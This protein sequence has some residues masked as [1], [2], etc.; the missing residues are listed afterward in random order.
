M[1][2]R[3]NI[4]FKVQET[5]VRSWFEE[6]LRAGEAQRKSTGI[7][8]LDRSTPLNKSSDSARRSKEQIEKLHHVHTEEP[9]VAKMERVHEQH[10]S[11]EATRYLKAQA[12]PS[13]WNYFTVRYRDDSVIPQQDANAE[14]PT[15]PTNAPSP[16][17]G[18]K[19][20][21][22]P[23]WD[24]RMAVNPQGARNLEARS[25]AQLYAHQ[26]THCAIDLVA[27]DAYG[28]ASDGDRFYLLNWFRHNYRDVDHG[29]W[30]ALKVPAK[31]A[32]ETLSSDLTLDMYTMEQWHELYRQLIV[33]ESVH[34]GEHSEYAS[35]LRWELRDDAWRYTT[36]VLKLTPRQ[37]FEKT[38]FE[39]LLRP[40]NMDLTCVQSRDVTTESDAL[41]G[42]TVVEYR[43]KVDHVGAPSC[44]E[45]WPNWKLVNPFSSAKF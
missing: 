23:L 42:Q 33:V 29:V 45:R 8:L 20:Y 5:G 24:A 9:H 12:Q 18:D 4:D 25:Y 2:T 26:S 7:M 28:Y 6:V 37:V 15:A 16:H 40:A 1:S 34:V 31:A 27:P 39:L 3:Q 17:R 43:A 21:P 13:T 41:F 14:V 10:H 22:L 30:E 44:E 36:Q 35:G 11:K 32:V 38:M 19:L